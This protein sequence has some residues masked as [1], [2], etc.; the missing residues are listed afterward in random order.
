MEEVGRFVVMIPGGICRCC[1]DAMMAKMEK[2]KRIGGS[3]EDLR[4]AAL[5]MK[6]RG[7]G[8]LLSFTLFVPAGL[9]LPSVYLLCD[10]DKARGMGWLVFYD[11]AMEWGCALVGGSDII[12]SVGGTYFFFVAWLLGACLRVNQACE[13][14]LALVAGDGAVVRAA[15]LM[16]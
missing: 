7:S 16:L 3:T 11:V 13:W 6:M 5:K 15:T 9:V 10:S 12:I 14:Q 1:F 2:M 8:D 4:R